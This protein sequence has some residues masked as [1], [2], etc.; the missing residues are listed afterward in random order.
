MV[1]LFDGKIKFFDYLNFDHNLFISISFSM[2]LLDQLMCV[3]H[4]LWRKSLINYKKTILS[5]FVVILFFF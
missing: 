4:V 3:K 2:M 1:K 5:S